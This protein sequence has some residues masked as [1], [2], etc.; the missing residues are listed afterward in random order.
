[1]NSTTIAFF[2]T[3]HG[4]GHASRSAAVMAALHFL[5]PNLRFEI[6]TASPKW[7]FTDSLRT[8]F[9]YHEIKTD[10]GPVQASPLKEDLPATCRAL[11]R[12]LPFD[13]DL[14]DGLAGQL[15]GLGCQLVV[16]DISPLGIAVA[17]RASLPS[18]LVE[19]FTWDWIYTQYA[20]E[21]PELNIAA[22]MLNEVY[23]QVDLRI[24]T[25]PLCVPVEGTPK[26]DPIY[27][28]PRT[29]R[30]EIRDRLGISGSQKM[31]LVTM[32]GVPDRFEFVKS[33]P[34][35]IDPFLV[36]PGADGLNC[37]HPKVILLS[38]HSS[39]YHP[40]LL[41]AADALIGKAGYSTIAEICHTGQP[42]GY[43]LRRRSPESVYLG[44][45]IT[46]YLSAVSIPE[47]DHSTG[48]W[49]KKLPNLLTLA[50]KTPPFENGAFQTARLL[51]DKFLDNR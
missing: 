11:D 36:I 32:G 18:V 51:L 43:I 20:A 10:L 40:D 16:C 26:V 13:Q 50:P 6:F 12:W 4:F 19:N 7:I 34:E 27:R 8:P 29:G 24:Q 38:A 2:V 35:E 1:M 3:D 17:N 21:F 14:V 9:G 45:F 42:F 28:W 47:E 22:D 33:L 48:Q 49:I 25:E 41:N 46:T 44:R 15:A 30:Q 23:Q 5:M 31:V 39:F 37:N